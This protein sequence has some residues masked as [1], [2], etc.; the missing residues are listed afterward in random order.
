MSNQIVVSIINYKTVEMTIRCAQS[1]LD[2]LK[3]HDGL[4]VVV[5]NASDDGSDT[6]LSDWVADHAEKARLKLVLSQINTGFSGGHNL[7]MGAAEA[8]FYLLLNSDALLQPGFFEAMMPVAHANPKAGLI[9]PVIQ[10]E[11][12]HIQDSCFRFH[13]PGSEIIRAACTGPVT[14]L[15][16]RYDVSLGTDPDTDQIDWV[17]FACVLLRGD[18]VA[19]LGPMDEGY[20]LYYEDA[21]YSL[22]A[23]RAGWQIARAADARAV[24]FRGGSGPVKELA[25]AKKR[26]PP[27]YY[28]SRTRFFRQAYGALGPVMANLGWYMG[29]VIAQARRLT[30]RAPYAM[31]EAEARDIWTNAFNP[32]GPRRA[33]GDAS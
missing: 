8:D 5:D 30:G 17:S 25:K 26:M 10:G 11:D 24:H 23:G 7:G 1:A 2:A 3:G 33:P 32:L 14:R 15:L 22:R 19:D 31:N 6:V 13:S 16:K 28:A 4:V 21:E 29:R 9:A 20:F 18:M 27:Y 12:G